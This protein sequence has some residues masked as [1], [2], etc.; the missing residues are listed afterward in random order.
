MDDPVKREWAMSRLQ[1][2]QSKL[3]KGESIGAIEALAD[4]SPRL[5]NDPKKALKS[6]KETAERKQ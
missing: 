4:E 2:L 1:I 6:I 3:N 5:L